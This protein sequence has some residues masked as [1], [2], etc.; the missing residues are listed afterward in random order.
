MIEVI[1][2]LY[3]DTLSR[4][5]TNVF[6][7]LKPK[8]VLITTPNREFNVVFD[9]LEN[10]EEGP[11]AATSETLKP[12]ETSSYNLNEQKSDNGFRHWDHK[13]EWT[14]NEFE[15]W[16]HNE[17]LKKFPNYSLHGQFS[18]LGEPPLEH[19]DVGYCTQ[20]ALFARNDLNPSNS[21]MTTS[22]IP[23]NLLESYIKVVSSLKLF[24]L[25]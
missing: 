2:H 12:M 20:M 10:D 18:G 3:P 14:R 11:H 13:F 9:E 24:F 7:L 17:I 23:T 16:C 6:G 19:K 21:T 22:S 8:Y 5:I 15:T 4:C 25:F 1:E